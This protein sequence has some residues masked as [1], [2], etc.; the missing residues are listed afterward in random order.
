MKEWLSAD[1]I[2]FKKLCWKLV[3]D[4]IQLKFSNLTMSPLDLQQACPQTLTNKPYCEFQIPPRFQSSMWS[5]SILLSTACHKIFNFQL[6]WKS[7]VLPTKLKRQ[8]Q[9]PTMNVIPKLESTTNDEMWWRIRGRWI[10]WFVVF[11]SKNSQW[12][13]KILSEFSNWKLTPLIFCKMI[14]IGKID[15]VDN[16]AIFKLKQTHEPVH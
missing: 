3:E 14:F 1:Q 11:L 2:L 12:L 8:L 16:N 13:S 6:K 7:R 4:T 9:L 10:I 15:W 5:W